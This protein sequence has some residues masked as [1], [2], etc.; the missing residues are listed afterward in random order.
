MYAGSSGGGGGP[1]QAREAFVENSLVAIKIDAARGEGEY[2]NALAELWGCPS[3]DYSEFA[4]TL[5]NHY[6]SLFNQSGPVLDKID[7]II[8]S[9]SNLK[10]SCLGVN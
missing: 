10:A 4:S 3:E 2:L 6:L 1:A 8:R 5:H 9:Q 7:S